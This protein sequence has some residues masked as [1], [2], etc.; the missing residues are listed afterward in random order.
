MAYYE[1]PRGDFFIGDLSLASGDAE[2]RI[3]GTSAS[4]GECR[5]HEWTTNLQSGWNG[6]GQPGNATPPCS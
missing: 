6:S 3:S 1:G 2:W 5:A 4:A